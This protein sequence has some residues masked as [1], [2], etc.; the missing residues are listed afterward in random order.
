MIACGDAS[1]PIGWQPVDV[2]AGGELS[3]LPEGIGILP[4]LDLPRAAQ[5][6]VP[7]RLTYR[8]SQGDI[9]VWF[10]AAG[11]GSFL[12]RLPGYGHGFELD[13]LTF[14]PP[15]PW[16]RTRVVR[17][18]FRFPP[19]HGVGLCTSRCSPSPRTSATAPARSPT[20]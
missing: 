13:L 12:I 1:P 15:R 8:G 16:S 5:P 4:M 6:D 19:F 3:S 18:T 17:C 9:A 14:L 20:F 7:F 10:L 2:Q 11:N